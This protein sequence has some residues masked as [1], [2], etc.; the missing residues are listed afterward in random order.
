MGHRLGLH[1]V[2]YCA[3]TDR[4]MEGVSSIAC[5]FADRQTHACPK[6][7]VH[8]PVEEAPMLFRTVKFVH[9]PAERCLVVPEFA[10]ELYKEAIAF[11]MRMSNRLDASI[12]NMKDYDLVLSYVCVCIAK[13]P[14]A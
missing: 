3:V 9:E 5:E 8:G 4:I 10:Q 13:Y 11:S 6:S 2:S 12:V 1:G 14:H 7:F